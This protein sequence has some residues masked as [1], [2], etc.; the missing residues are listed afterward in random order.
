MA[1]ARNT[2]GSAARKITAHACCVL[3]LVAAV[4]IAGA[5]AAQPSVPVTA[6][7]AQ[8]RPAEIPPA[9][10]PKISYVGGQLK[11]DAV[12]A[13]L[14]DV[15]AK[16]AALTG[17]AIDVPAA[18]RTERMPVVELGPGPAREVLASLLSDSNFDYLIQAS[19]SDPA[20]LQSVLL[21]PREK[22]GSGS[23][24]D[25]GGRP[26]RSPFVR[27]AA[28]PV[29][30][31]E[32]PVTDNNAVQTPENAAAEAAVNPQAATP[33]ADPQAQSDQ[34]AQPEP[35]V[36]PDLSAQGTFTSPNSSLQIP[37]AQ[38]GLS[39]GAMSPPTTLNSQTINQ[40]LQQMFQMRMQMNQQGQNGQ[41]PAVK[42]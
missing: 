16:V 22:K 23:T 13:T 31:E 18:A 29:K 27:A 1:K 33:Q 36:Q 12:N 19:D 41:A 39:K 37:L 42:Q 26:A 6:T 14:G 8:T 7:A 35:S 15:L 5:Q 3:A 40:Q 10:P 24:N 32:T 30:T 25:T 9:T 4:R 17:V 21:M 2:I 38:P 11:I 28:P 34:A 20:R